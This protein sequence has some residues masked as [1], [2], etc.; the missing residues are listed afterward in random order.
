MGKDY[1]H[2]IMVRYFDYDKDY[3]TYK[4]WWDGEVP[5]K[6]FLPTVGFSVEYS[7]ELIACGFLYQTDSAFCVFDWFAC[8]PK[9]RRAERKACL[10]ALVNS[11]IFCAKK[12]N[13]KIIYTSVQNK[14]FVKLLLE[15]G[16][17]DSAI[18]CAQHVFAKVG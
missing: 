10:Q 16:F 13:F 4:S 12:L 15:S 7:G 17:Q 3:Q 2:N 9:I 11:V 5:D 6:E 14:S 18:N 8:S 1:T